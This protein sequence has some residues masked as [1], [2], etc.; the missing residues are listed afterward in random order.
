M[1]ANLFFSFAKPLLWLLLNLLP[2]KLGFLASLA[3]I[4][5][6][7]FDFTKETCER[8]IL[9]HCTLLHVLSPS[10]MK[11]ERTYIHINVRERERESLEYYWRS[12]QHGLIPFIPKINFWIRKDSLQTQK[13]K[14]KKRADWYF[15]SFENFPLR[16]FFNEGIEVTTSLVLPR[17]LNLSAGQLSPVFILVAKTQFSRKIQVVHA[18]RRFFSLG[19]CKNTLENS[20]KM[21]TSLYEDRLYLHKTRYNHIKRC[22]IALKNPDKLLVSCVT[23]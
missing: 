7:F 9:I 13:N 8:D 18:I 10:F 14:N 4:F 16:Y 11:W 1:C 3:N 19:L 6:F 23:T 15:S 17:E 21:F 22:A 2:T 5:F 20:T 12:N